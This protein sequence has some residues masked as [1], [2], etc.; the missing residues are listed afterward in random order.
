MTQAFQ[1]FG[2]PNQPK[3]DPS[4]LFYPNGDEK[5]RPQIVPDSV[6]VQPKNLGPVLQIKVWAPEFVVQRKN[7]KEG[8]ELPVC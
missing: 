8:R 2:L 6:I 1:N 3:S 5:H 7:T 4:Y